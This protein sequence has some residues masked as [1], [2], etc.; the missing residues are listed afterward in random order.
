MQ[1]IGEKKKNPL[2]YWSRQWGKKEAGRRRKEEESVE[3]EKQV[4]E[5][6]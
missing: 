3:K 4:L 6:D 1:A 5:K 2:R